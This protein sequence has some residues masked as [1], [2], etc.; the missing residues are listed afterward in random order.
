MGYLKQFFK[1]KQ[2]LT[3]E[4]LNH[5][6]EGIA[7]VTEKVENLGSSGNTGGTAVNL[8]I[9]TVTSGETAAA[10][11]V[12]GKLNLV[13]PRGAQGPQGERGLQGET[14][15][16]GPTGATGATGAAG[17]AGANGKDGA[18]GVQ[19]PQGETGPAGPGF[20]DTAKSLILSLFEGAAYGNDAM[21]AQLES[22]KTEWNSSTGGDV[23][24]V[25]SVSL[26]KSTLSL[27]VGNS[28]TLTATV[29]PS[30]ATNKTVTWSVSPE[31]YAAL[32]AT[33]GT[34]V[35]VTASKAGS[36]T[37]TASA[38]GKS[39]ACAVTVAAASAD[40][41]D[42]PGETPVYKLAEATEF[43]PTKAN[44]IDTGVKMLSSIDPKPSYTILF[45]V[46]Y[47][48]TLA[49]QKDTYVLLHCM[50]ESSPWPGFVVQVGSSGRLQINMYG[51]E[52]VLDD[53]ADIT[54]NKRKFAVEFYD[55]KIKGISYTGYYFTG[56]KDTDYAADI[57]NY[58]A[59]V[60]KSL[61]LGAYQQSDG[62]KGRYF[63]GTLYQCLIYDKAL[64]P[65][66]MVAWINS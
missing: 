33:S 59:A 23:V 25:Q 28:E 39:A 18:Q 53:K 60:D 2:K 19:G 22:L 66:Q 31:G 47:N 27:T 51:F 62:T 4:Q 65:A 16:Q 49:A 30:N 44:C 11:I 13:L 10:S 58:T 7:D 37:V 29:L 8:T 26:N 40:T 9:G 57:T 48:E 17:P 63:D 61:I 41:E 50:E 55:D 36:C 20:T 64:T 35:T 3:A 43:T 38:G 14:G 21:Q 45:E 32:S 46:Q 15:P 6:E 5:M 34:S 12:D 42:V 1:S 24:A 56:T 52:K 54:A